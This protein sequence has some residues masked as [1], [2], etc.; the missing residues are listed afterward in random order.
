MR[1]RRMVG[2]VVAT[3]AA[4]VLFAS[5]A[6]A[7]RW[8]ERPFTPN[9]GNAGAPCLR[10][11]GPDGQIAVTGPL[12]RHSLEIDFLRATPAGLRRDGHARIPPPDFDCP[13]VAAASDGTA[14]VASF[15]FGEPRGLP[16]V[17]AAVRDP[18]TRF[19]RAGGL[20]RGF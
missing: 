13:A 8:G 4:L 16:R 7:A 9:R 17:V 15:A 19:G 1:G 11:A 12:H 2:A 10:S 20:S 18:G 5:A 3:A 14:V 6:P